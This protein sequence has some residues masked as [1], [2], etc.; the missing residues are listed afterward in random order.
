MDSPISHLEDSRGEIAKAWLMRVVERA[1]LEEIERLPTARVARELPEVVSEI[2][3]ALAPG[4]ETQ[5][6]EM[7]DWAHRLAD[8]SG[9]EVPDAKDL[10]RDLSALQSVMLAELHRAL[11]RM[12]AVSVLATVERLAELFSALHADAVE[13]LLSARSSELEWLGTTDSLT[14]LQ[15]TRF[16]QQHMNHLIGVQKRYGHPFALLLLDID[17]LKRINDAY[18][19]TAG[20][21]TLVGVATAVG[22]SIRN[23]D[24]PVRMGGDEFCVLLPHQTASRARVLAERLAEAI[25]RVENPASQPLGVAIGVASCPQHAT[26]ADGLLEV[27]DGAMYR[28]KAAGERVAVG[29]DGASQNGDLIDD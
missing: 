8:L 18:G 26:D 27:A 28:A 19:S 3:R 9:R 25:E 16:M 6:A 15:N 20:D 23:V 21:R 13:D 10:V 29:T 4:V 17:G 14:G 22:E 5:S 2:S 7:V 12:E 11:D 1:S 24:T